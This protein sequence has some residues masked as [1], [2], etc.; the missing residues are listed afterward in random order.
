M[1][2]VKFFAFNPFSENTY[3]VSASSGAA[4]LI[5]PG[6]YTPEETNQLKNYIAEKNLT[7]IE[8]LL[9]HAHIDHVLGLQWAF[10]TFGLPVKI[11][12]KDVEILERN[13]M[14]AKNYGFF[15]PP[16]S[17]KLE[18]IEEGTTLKLDDYT[19]E[20]LHVPG[21]SPGSIV[22]HCAEE[23]LIISGDVLFEGSIGRTDLYKG[24]HHDL[25]DNITQK[26]WPLPEET[27]VYCGHGNPTTFGFEKNYNPFF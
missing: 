2:T 13:P 7:I 4:W 15:I 23:K 21:H 14:T 16:F 12:P 20:T 26:L 1:L 18:E 19:F 6:N 11:H 10:D 9:T 3:I 8:I 27:K 24:N 5:D 17:G 25:I 22:Y